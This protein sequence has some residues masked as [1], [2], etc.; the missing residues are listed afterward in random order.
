[1]RCGVVVVAYAG[2]VIAVVGDL[3]ERPPLG[4]LAVEIAA[5][6][7][8]RGAVVQAVGVLTVDAAGDRRMIDLA[9]MGIGHAAVL[10][11]PAVALEPAD[12]ELALRYLPDLGALV[13][14]GLPG[15]AATAAAGAAFAV[16]P[17]VI[18][19]AGEPV[20]DALPDDALVLGAPADDPDGAFAGLVAELAA[21]LDA[22]AAPAAAWGDTLRAL[23]IEGRRAR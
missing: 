23:V 12:L 15:L 14:V 5:R 10:R 1:M 13:L 17:L 4:G 6:I 22:G 11:S 21:R 20:R 16:A 18:V 2:R 19:A 9:G 8:R 3:L 7:A